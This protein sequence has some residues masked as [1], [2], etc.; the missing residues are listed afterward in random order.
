MPPTP[1]MSKGTGSLA[2]KWRKIRKRCSSFSSPGD[3]NFSDEKGIDHNASYAS[4]AINASLDTDSV[5]R[6]NLGISRSKS[7]SDYS[8]LIGVEENVDLKTQNER[9]LN[10]NSPRNHL[11]SNCMQP[12]WRD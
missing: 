3:A 5:Q 1:L 7:V 12:S 9:T 4:N 11:N 6:N 8:R 10:Q 2:R